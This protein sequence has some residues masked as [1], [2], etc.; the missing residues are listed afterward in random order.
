MHAMSPFKGQGANQSLADG[1]VVAQWLLRARLGPA[2]QGA[3]REIVQ[4]TAPVVQA[5]REAALFWHSPHAWQRS[6]QQHTFAGVTSSRIPVHLLQRTLAEA[7]ITASTVD[8]LDSAIRSQLCKVFPTWQGA[9]DDEPAKARCA[10]SNTDKLVSKALQAA[11]RNDLETLRLLTWH[12]NPRFVQSVV[13]PVTGNTCLHQAMLVSRKQGVNDQVETPIVQ[14][15]YWSSRQQLVQWLV[16]E[17]GCDLEQVNHNGRKPI[18]V[19][20]VESLGLERKSGSTNDSVEE[21][22]PDWWDT[23]QRWYK[24]HRL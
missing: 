16:T 22:I 15:E 14:E 7:N 1:A 21:G 17:A 8:D 10:L 9:S 3:M 13:D 11:E 4:R 18:D 24:H 12:E 20:L 23:L 19:A 5:S 2:V 6:D